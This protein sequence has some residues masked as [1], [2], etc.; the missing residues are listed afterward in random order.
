MFIIPIDYSSIVYLVVSF[1][2]WV[3]CVVSVHQQGRTAIASYI[4]DCCKIN[5]SIKWYSSHIATNV[6]LPTGSFVLDYGKHNF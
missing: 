3:V 1:V 4:A 5:Q 6:E 2:M